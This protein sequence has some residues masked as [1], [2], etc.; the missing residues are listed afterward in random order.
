MRLTHRGLPDDD[1]VKQHTIG[2]THYLDRLSVR[3]SGG[4]PGPD[5]MFGESE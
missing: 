4:D 2:W 3:A 1:A 5:V